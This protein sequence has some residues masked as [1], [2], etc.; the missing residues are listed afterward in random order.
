MRRFRRGLTALIGIGI[1]IG[2]SGCGSFDPSDWFNSKKPL[3]GER[4]LVFPEGVPGVPQGVPKE[5]V[6]GNEPSTTDTAALIGV[7]SEPAVTAKPEASASTSSE[8]LVGKPKPWTGPTSRPRGAQKV[9]SRPKTKK[10]QQA[11]VPSSAAPTAA[12]AT[13]TRITIAPTRPA[14][15][16]NGKSGTLPSGQSPADSAVWGPTPGQPAA[17]TTA[18]GA[19][20]PWPAAKPQPMSNAPWPDSPPPNQFSR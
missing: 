10:P 7:G 9:A 13:P 8:K 6:K 19:A 3:P 18:S 20:A 17:A 1:G 14:A 16:A 15:Q 2:L 11:K 4:H 12:A 5:L